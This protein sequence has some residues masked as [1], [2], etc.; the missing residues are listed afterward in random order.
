MTLDRDRQ[1]KRRSQ[2]IVF[3]RDIAIA[4]AGIWFFEFYMD[5]EFPENEN[6]LLYFVAVPIIWSTLIH[7]WTATSYRGRTGTR[8][9]FS[10]LPCR[11]DRGVVVDLLRR[12]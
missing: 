7:I 9:E 11:V 6:L 3:V 1:T 2:F 5:Y 4:I 8:R 10:L 12:G